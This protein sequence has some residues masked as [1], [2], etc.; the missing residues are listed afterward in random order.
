MASCPPARPADKAPWSDFATVPTGHQTAEHHLTVQVLWPRLGMLG[1]F[2]MNNG[3]YEY[4]Q[5]K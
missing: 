4:G 5:I 1:E 3:L 2:C